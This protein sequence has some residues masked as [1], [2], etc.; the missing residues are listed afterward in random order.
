MTSQFLH[1][2]CP[3]CADQFLLKGSRLRVWLA[4][5]ERNPARKGPY[6]SYH[7]SSR[8]NISNANNRRAEQ[9]VLSRY[10]RVAQSAEAGTL[11]VLQ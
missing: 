8:A 10:A 9:A 1:A 7:C 5:K 4:A 2:V 6:C 11:K 3:E